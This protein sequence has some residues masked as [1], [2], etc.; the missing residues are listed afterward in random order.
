MNPTQP[1]N[2]SRIVAV[3]LCGLLLTACGGEGS[4][5]SANADANSAVDGQPAPDAHTDTTGGADA[6]EG[7]DTTPTNDSRDGASPAF[8]IQEDAGAPS[9]DHT[10]AAAIDPLTQP[11]GI[12]MG[13]EL[14]VSWSAFQVN[15]Y[16]TGYFTGLTSSTGVEI[17][18]LLYSVQNPPGTT[19]AASALAVFPTDPEPAEP[20]MVLTWNHGTTGGGDSC[21]PSA[22]G[23]VG[24]FY[25]IVL[26][27][28]GY[29]VVL[30]DY[31]GLG[32]PGP[33]PYMVRDVT[34][35]A[36]VDGVRAIRG[37]GED[38]GHP[39]S[40]EVERKKE[41]RTKVLHSF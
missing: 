34:G 12:V 32:T 28:M 4:A 18:H 26:A 19:Q 27:S 15:S 5:S 41:W 33:H 1:P 22:A 30:P 24:A 13:Q 31:P 7:E 39:L 9:A 8:E 2:R 36:V 29:A 40:N 17:Y 14:V 35:M 37:L 3:I 10:D 11:Q 6:I 21:A 25:G 38:V 23:T 16:L 20:P